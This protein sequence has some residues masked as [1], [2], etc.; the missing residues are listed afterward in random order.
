VVDDPVLTTFENFFADARQNPDVAARAER[1][2]SGDTA[3]ASGPTTTW[4]V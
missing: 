3:S 4:W 1:P 2:R